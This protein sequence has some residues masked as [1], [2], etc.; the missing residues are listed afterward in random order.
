MQIQK[1]KL[2]LCLLISVI[3][4]ILLSSL[5]L[6]GLFSGW[7]MKLGDALYKQKEP[8]KNLIIVAIDDT[9]LQEVGRWPW[10][11]E[12]FI[13]LLPKL[14]DSE[15]IGIDI[16]F[17]ENYNTKIDTQLGDEIAKLGN[18]ILPV[19]YAKFEQGKGT[20]ILE[21]IEPI[22]KNAAGIGFVNIFSDSDGIAR[23]LPLQISGDESK[24]IKSYDGF[25]LAIYK[26]LLSRNLSYEEKS[27]RFLINFVGKPGSFKTISFVD[28]LNNN[29][30]ESLFENAIVLIGAT[31]PDLH[32]D[33]FV[34]TSSGKS[35]SGIELHANALQTMITKQFLQ[36]ESNFAIIITILAVS[37]II[38]LLLWKLRLSIAAIGAL[39]LILA[40]AL[41]AI[42]MFNKGIIANLFYPPL[43]IIITYVSTIGIYYVLA[44]KGRKQ[45]LHLFGKYVSK[46]VVNEIMKNAKEGITQLKGTE[47]EVT[48][49][50]ADIRGFTPVSERL[51]P[52]EVVTM[53]NTY[54]GEMTNVVF[55]Y[56][57][58]LDKFIGDCVM[59]IF[60]APVEQQNS[61]LLAVK[62]ALEMQ[63]KIKRVHS[64]HGKKIPIMHAGIGIN[65]GQ[66][67]IGNIG[68]KDRMEYTA[69][70]DNVNLASR[71]C[72]FAKG[73][74]IVIS[75]QT[76]NL[77]KDKIVSKKLGEIKVKG[78]SKPLAVYEVVRL[79]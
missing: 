35:M 52:K 50:F 15:V 54:L 14:S 60:N 51:K 7:Q 11:R 57:G 65:T 30:E 67:I 19:E 70:G 25:T 16:A 46:E 26:Q 41:I 31:S 6:L 20:E 21:T 74:Q 8:L 34:P 48:I 1:N 58:T 2:V 3:V 28:V 36:N 24:E 33:Y 63:D 72:S 43:S 12:R 27:N 5:F 39:I 77:V 22:K 17:F 59:A 9:S 47:R 49:L 40:Y 42:I 69:I 45:V 76:Y 10:P 61:A 73:G 44:E 37:F 29:Y 53:L 75:Q 56:R 66:A 38:G 18:V 23:A 62:A 78:K 4:A 68:T 55:K 32:D 71:L 13:E 79:K 64:V